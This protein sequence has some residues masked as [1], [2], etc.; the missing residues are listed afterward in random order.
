MID[1]YILICL[2]HQ[3][4]SGACGTEMK[5]HAVVYPLANFN[6]IAV[7]AESMYRRQ[8]TQAKRALPSLCAIR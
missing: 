2:G 3:K 4:M 1:K 5:A 8:H 7:Y 6:Y